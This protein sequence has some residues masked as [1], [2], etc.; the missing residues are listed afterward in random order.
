MERAM[1]RIV[2]KVVG[3]GWLA[4]RAGSVTSEPRE[5][6]RFRTLPEAECAAQRLGFAFECLPVEDL[7]REVPR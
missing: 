1:Q 4:D 6:V 7:W 3:V 5:A 2:V